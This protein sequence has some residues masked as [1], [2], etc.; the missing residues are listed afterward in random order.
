MIP[1]TAARLYNAASQITSRPVDQTARTQAADVESR[2]E[3][4]NLLLQTLLMILLEKQIIHED[5]FKEWMAYVDDLDGA[6]D[7]KIREDHSP[8]EC[9]DCGRKSPRTAPKCLYCGRAFE[10]EFLAR[11]PPAPPSPPSETE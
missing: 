1:Y 3:R 9:P 8:M 10:T 2:L 4:T 6:R 5:E 7:G 11:R